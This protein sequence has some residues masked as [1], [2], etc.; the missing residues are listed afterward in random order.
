MAFDERLAGRIRQAISKRPGAE[1]KK[2][3]GGLAFLDRGRMFCGILGDDL[4]VRVGAEAHEE[5]VTKP[6]VRPMDFTG[7]S[8][9]GY[10]YV[11]PG[12]YRTK[13]TLDRWIEAGLKGAAAAPAKKRRTSGKKAR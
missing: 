9:K 6:H 3:F 11:G 13:Q 12:G 8:M 4:V 7:R 2:M 1:E 5:L 10:V